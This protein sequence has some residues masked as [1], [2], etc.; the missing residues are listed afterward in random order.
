MVKN[1]LRAKNIEASIKNNKIWV[2]NKPLN[3]K[4]TNELLNKEEG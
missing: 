2:D 3:L 4:E 1:K